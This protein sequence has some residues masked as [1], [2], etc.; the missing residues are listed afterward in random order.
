MNS[1][2]LSLPDILAHRKT[3]FSNYLLDAHN[4]LLTF[5]HSHNWNEYIVEPFINEAKIFAKKED[6]D[7]ALVDFFNLEPDTSIPPTYCATLER[8]VLF[9]VTPELYA[10]I[11]PQ[12]VE[13]NFYVKL[14]VASSY[15]VA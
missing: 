6:F 10:K 7:G 2:V 9:I 3:E 13:E 4:L 8:K 15:I 1:I 14:I 12:G 11:Y 5:T